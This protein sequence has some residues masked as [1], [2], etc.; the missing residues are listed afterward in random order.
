MINENTRSIA[1]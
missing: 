1:G